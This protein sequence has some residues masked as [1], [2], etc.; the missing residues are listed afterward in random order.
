L[1]RFLKILELLLKVEKATRIIYKKEERYRFK[2]HVINIV[3]NDFT[4][5]KNIRW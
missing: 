1:L 5:G 2:D 4:L 3:R